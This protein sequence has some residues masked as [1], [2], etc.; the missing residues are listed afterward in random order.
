M[1]FFFFFF[2]AE[3][4]IRDWSVTGVQT[5]ALP[6]WFWGAASCGRGVVMTSSADR[7][8]S[9]NVWFSPASANH[10]L[11]SSRTLSGYSAARSCSSARSVSV[12]YSSQVSSLKWPQPLSVGWVVTAFQPSR[13][14]PREPSIEKNWVLRADG[15]EAISTL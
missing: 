15:A 10:R 5:C 8:S 2:Q 7:S 1:Y 6:I 13:Q 11:T 9:G 12:W 4:G 3:D 14:I